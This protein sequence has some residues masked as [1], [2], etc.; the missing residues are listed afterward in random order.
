LNLA[1]VAGSDN[2]GWGRTAVA[3][4]VFRIPGWR[5]MTPVEIDEAIQRKMRVDRHAAGRVILRR[6]PDPGAS[7]LLLAATPVT[8]PWTMVRALNL[9]ERISWT[10]WG[11]TL[12]G[13]CML[14]WPFARRAYRGAFDVRIPLLERREQGEVSLG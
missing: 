5:Q 3:W 1:L 9:K 12:W 8:V 7:W 4:S 14:P 11:W 6:S 13:L 10:V 2:H